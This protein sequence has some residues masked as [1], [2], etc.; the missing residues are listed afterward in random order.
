MPTNPLLY[1]LLVLWMLP[2]AGLFVL[3]GVVRW[4]AVARRLGALPA[5][6]APASVLQPEVVR[7]NGQP[8]AVRVAVGEYGGEVSALDRS[9]RAR[10]GRPWC[11]YLN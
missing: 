2:A 8:F 3:Y 5:S 10:H 4:P 9:G 11:V 7:W 6:M 1:V